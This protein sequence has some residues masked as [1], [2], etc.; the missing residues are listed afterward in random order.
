VGLR[1]LLPTDKFKL[2][3]LRCATRHDPDYQRQV[4]RLVREQ[5]VPSLS[6]PTR[7]MHAF[8]AADDN[9]KLLGAVALQDH[10]AD[11]EVAVLGVSI[12]HRRS[13][14][15]RALVKFGVASPKPAPC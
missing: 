10:G 7:D 2:R 8:V 15:A 6:D 1:P 3:Q 12:E 11:W 13:G 5:L 9:G 14:L 4:A